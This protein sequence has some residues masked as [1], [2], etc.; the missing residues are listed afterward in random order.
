MGFWRSFQLHGVALQRSSYFKWHCS[1]NQKE[2]VSEDKTWMENFFREAS[3]E[4]GGKR[5]SSG[6][7]IFLELK[8]T[9]Q[10]TQHENYWRKQ[11]RGRKPL[12]LS[13]HLG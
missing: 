2:D 3:P 10:T 13:K 1:D 5:E 7:Q 12:Q 11:S 6:E 9:A 8:E 4:R